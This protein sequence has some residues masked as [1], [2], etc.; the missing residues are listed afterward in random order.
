MKETHLFA[1]RLQRRPLCAVPKEYI[2]PSLSVQCVC[3]PS[4]PCDS[5]FRCTFNPPFGAASPTVQLQ[6][7]IRTPRSANHSTYI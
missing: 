3:G 7:T 2:L 1:A 4:F 6:C 5:F